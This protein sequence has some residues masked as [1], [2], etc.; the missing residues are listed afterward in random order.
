MASMKIRLI[1]GWLSAELEEEEPEL[2]ES[3]SESTSMALDSATKLTRKACSRASC[4]ACLSLRLGILKGRYH[5]ACNLYSR[6]QW[7]EG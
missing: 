7:A 2:L 3:V 6:I 5:G 4:A 1:S